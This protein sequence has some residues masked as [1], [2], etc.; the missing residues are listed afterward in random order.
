M[1]DGVSSPA[2]SPIPVVSVKPGEFLFRAG[3]QADSFFIISKG[4]IELL[5]S[6]ADQ[7]R[8]ALLAERDICGEDA[9]FEGEARTYDARAVTAAMLLK[10]P[11][12]AFVDLL[13]V[14][15]ELASAVIGWTA[16]QLRRSRLACLTI[17]MPAAPGVRGSTSARFVHMESGAQFHLPE[18]D[19]VVVGRADPATKFQ[20]GI[21]LSAVDSHRSLS[22]RHAMIKRAGNGYQVIEQ[23]HVANGT[24]VNGKRISEGAAV[25]IKDGDEVTFGL[26]TTVFRTT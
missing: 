16:G 4:Q 23:G 8:L 13:R 15:P 9:A 26:I 2:E 25:P 17:A 11:I 1:S 7:R 21:E 3:E 22:R 12:T 18:S 24:F 10:V 20:P 14:R 19:D 5:K 6:G